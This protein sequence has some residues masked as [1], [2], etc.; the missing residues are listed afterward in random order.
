MTF[1]A[2]RLT[3][4][5][6]PISAPP[7]K[8]NPSANRF[9]VRVESLRKKI[10]EMQLREPTG[11]VTLL[12]LKHIHFILGQRSHQDRDQ[13]QCKQGHCQFQRTQYAKKP[14]Q[15][16]DSTIIGAW[17]RVYGRCHVF[18]AVRVQAKRLQVQFKGVQ[19]RRYRV[20][21]FHHRFSRASHFNEEIH[22]PVRPQRKNGRIDG[23]PLIRIFTC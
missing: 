19:E 18:F 1:A 22:F 8:W 12:D 4:N 21:F 14:R 23:Q 10:V 15:A 2:T 20:R 16:V 9:V 3:I 13:R 5:N 17:C 11:K 7:R 6:K